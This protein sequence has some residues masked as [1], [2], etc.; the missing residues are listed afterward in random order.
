MEEVAKKKVYE[1]SEIGEIIQAIL[2]VLGALLVP[3]VV[4]QILQ[5]VFGKGSAIASN[6][7]LIVGSIVNTALIMSGLNLKGWRRILAV[8]TLPSLS[9]ISSGFIFGSLTKVTIFMVP[10]IWLGNFSLIM[11]M[12]YLY[13]NK[14]TNYILSAV[15][16]IVVKV[17]IIFS[18]LNI[19]MLASVLPNQGNVADTLRNTMGLT[20]L[21]TATIGAIISFAI[22]KM[23]VKLQEKQIKE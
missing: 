20:Q 8:A 17:A 7:Q 16:S 2:I 14:K 12:K 23:F 15:I 3:A 21:I 1:L 5:F 22:M 18:V 9:A 6:S 4:P 11:L 10:G 19:W 13:A